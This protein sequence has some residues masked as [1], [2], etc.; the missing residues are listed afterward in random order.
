MLVDT[1]AHLDF[2]EF[3][4]DVEAVMRRAKDAGISRVIAIGTSLQSSHKAIHLAERYPE[5]YAVIGVHPSAVSEERED[6]LS[7]LLAMADHPKVVAIGETGLDYHHL[8]G[9]LRWPPRRSHLSS[10][11]N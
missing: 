3:A 7:E 10:I 2:P 11:W 1:H 9:A 6:F 5:L 8:P 4:D